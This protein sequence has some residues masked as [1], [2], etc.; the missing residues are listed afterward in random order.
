MFD[1]SGREKEVVSKLSRGMQQKVSLMVLLL[2]NPDI[3][4]LDEPTLGLD[5]LAVIQFKNFLIELSKKINKTIILCSHDVNFMMDLCDR[6]IILKDGKILYNK[7]KNDLMSKCESVYNVYLNIDNTS[8]IDKYHY[9]ILE[10]GVCKI[11]TSNLIEIIKEFNHNE[12]ISV[13]L[14]KNDIENVIKRMYEEK[15]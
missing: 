8:K 6:I 2:K 11:K 10:N 13:E 14:E 3:L 7:S 1:L 12:I 15:D 4:I 9:D 5:I